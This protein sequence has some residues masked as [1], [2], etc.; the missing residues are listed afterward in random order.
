MFWPG[1]LIGILA[2]WAL[3]S[4][5]GAMLGGVLGQ[6]LDRRMRQRT[7]RGLFEQLRGSGRVPDDELLFMLLGRL[8][9]IRGRVQDAHIQQARAEMLRLGLDEPAR[10]RAIDAFGRGKQGGPLLDEGLEQR[11]GQRPT[12]DGLLQACWRMAWA[13]GVPTAAEKALILR[14]GETLGLPRATVLALASG[15]EKVRAPLTRAESYTRALRLLGVEEGAEPAEIKRAYRRLISQHHPDKL[16]GAG[17]ARIAAATEKTREIQEA[18]SLIRERH[19][20][21]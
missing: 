1:T 14:W 18:Y 21:R 10:L 6:V 3:A 2:G 16:V 4:I 15:A 20:F 8:A 19:G 12:A 13:A 11:H 17:E 5:P 9:K 7:W